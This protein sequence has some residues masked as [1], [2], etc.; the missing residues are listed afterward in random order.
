MVLRQKGSDGINEAS[1]LRGDTV[2]ASDGDIIHSDCRNTYTNAK[3]ISD[4]TKVQPNCRPTRNLRSQTSSFQYHDPCLLYG[5]PA[6]YSGKKRGND[7]YPVRTSD[8]KAIVMQICIEHS[9]TWAYT[10]RGRIEFAQYLHATDA[11]YHRL[12]NTNVRTSKQH[13][14]PS[15]FQVTLG[16]NRRIGRP[17]DTAKEDAF[18]TVTKYLEDN[19]DEQITIRDLLNKMRDMCEHDVNGNS[20]QHMKGKLADRFGSRIVIDII[21]GKADVVTFRS[22]ASTILHEFYD[23]PKDEDSDVLVLLCHHADTQTQRERGTQIQ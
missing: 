8:F 12:C 10:V 17:F 19:T 3:A 9:D 13:L 2:R 15:T 16:K 22:T 11:I 20:E 1:R 18:L 4:I 21:N 14:L 6:K 5:Q 23:T 7:V